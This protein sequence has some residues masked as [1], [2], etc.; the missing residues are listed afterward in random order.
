MQ[1]IL[2]ENF[3][4]LSDGC[5]EL[6]REMVGRDEEKKEEWQGVLGTGEWRGLAAFGAAFGTPEGP[7]APVPLLGTQSLPGQLESSLSLGLCPPAKVFGAKKMPFDLSDGV[8]W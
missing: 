3:D 8:S 1:R 7:V 6:G 5:S 4:Q 2:W